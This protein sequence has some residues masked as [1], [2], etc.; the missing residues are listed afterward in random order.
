MVGVAEAGRDLLA[1]GDGPRGPGR[2]RQD[3]LA[4]AVAAAEAQRFPGGTWYGDVLPVTGPAMLP[5][6]VL[7]GLG[8]G[9]TSSRPAGRPAVA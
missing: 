8:L 4:L 6:T 1:A 5:A 3:R 9:E 2:N 7:A